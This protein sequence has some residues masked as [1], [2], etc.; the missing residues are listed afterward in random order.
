M[1]ER[2]CVLWELSVCCLHFEIC[3]ALFKHQL[4]DEDHLIL[5]RRSCLLALSEFFDS[6]SELKEIDHWIMV[7]LYKLQLLTLQNSVT[8]PST[9]YPWSGLRKSARFKRLYPHTRPYTR[10]LAILYVHP[11]RR[12]PEWSSPWNFP[13]LLLWG[14]RTRRSNL[15]SFSCNHRD[16]SLRTWKCWCS[17]NP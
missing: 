3:K 10:K 2:F 13:S 7:W 8:L 9:T 14:T 17:I 16:R 1:R 6:Y 12:F 4:V 11:C 5:I 15:D